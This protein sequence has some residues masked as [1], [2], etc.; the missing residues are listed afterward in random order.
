M[1][2]QAAIAAVLAAAGLTTTIGCGR[3]QGPRIQ[4]TLQVKETAA[5]AVKT[6]SLQDTNAVVTQTMRV[7]RARFADLDVA[8]LTIER[9]AGI[10]DRI[11]VALPRDRSFRE[12]KLKVGYPTLAR[13]TFS[14]RVA[15]VEWHRRVGD[16]ARA[17]EILLAPLGGRVPEGTR[18]AVMEVEEAKL[19]VLIED[20]PLLTRSDVKGAEATSDSWGRPAVNV[21]FTEAAVAKV[22]A[23]TRGKADESIALLLDD[24]V[25]AYFQ[26]RGPIETKMM[27][28]GLGAARAVTIAVALNRNPLAPAYVL[29]ADL[30]VLDEKVLEPEAM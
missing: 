6:P 8:D 10:P 3:S 26:V 19:V 7:L 28:S 18:V 9:V 4:Y 14:F 12:G 22:R 15:K 16:P 24:R 2:R 17:R 5:T 29:P 1:T 27:L 25:V 11:L 13:F 20:A 30:E 21:T 23:V